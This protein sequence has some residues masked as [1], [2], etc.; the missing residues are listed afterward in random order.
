MANASEL[1]Y[2]RQLSKYSNKE[3]TSMPNVTPEDIKKIKEWH[4][5]AKTIGFV[6]NYNK[7]TKHR[8]TQRT[9]DKLDELGIAPVNKLLTFTK[10]QLIDMGI[11]RGQV[12]TIIG[13]QQNHHNARVSKRKMKATKSRKT[14]RVPNSMLALF[15]GT[16]KELARRTAAESE[17]YRDLFSHDASRR[18]MDRIIV[19]HLNG[20]TVG[21]D[22]DRLTLSLK[23]YGTYYSNKTA[24]DELYYN[25]HTNET[26]V[27]HLS[28][29]KGIIH[30]KVDYLTHWGT[31]EINI[32]KYPTDAYDT[33]H[34][35]EV[36][37]C[38]KS[39]I[40]GHH[41]P[42]VEIVDQVVLIVAECLKE[43][44]NAIG[45]ECIIK[46]TCV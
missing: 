11:S 2:L 19:S 22:P 12:A 18:L 1:Q 14:N 33:D 15:Q 20:I 29:H 30:V 37:V 26:P 44:Y 28:I 23:K 3:L 31:R 38:W 27:C 5:F 10:Q 40:I 17:L 41:E 24:K 21:R 32:Y 7:R 13:W 43:Y 6:T 9:Y 8:L 25:L 34:R 36:V 45:K 46:T 39:A 42:V 16:N 35:Y 4:N